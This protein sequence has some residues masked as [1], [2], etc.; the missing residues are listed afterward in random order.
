MMWWRRGFLGDSAIKNPPVVQEKWVQSL[1]VKMGM[2]SHSSI[3][4]GEFHGQRSLV[5]C[6]PSDH[7][8]LDTTEA[9]ERALND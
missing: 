2:A 5:G 4:P 1:L 7:K 9:T 8:K 6:S 3:L